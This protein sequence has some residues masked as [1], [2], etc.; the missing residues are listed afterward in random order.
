MHGEGMAS[1]KSTLDSPDTGK[2]RSPA[3][4]TSF[5][6]WFGV[7][8]RWLRH[9]LARGIGSLPDKIDHAA[10]LTEVEDDGNLG[11]R[12]V[13][14]VVMSSAIAT[15]GLLLSSPAVIIGAMLISPLMGPIMLLGF[16]LCVLDFDSMK[17]SLTALAAGVVGALAIAIL[18]VMFSPLRE[19]T[20][21]ILARTRPNLF[22]LLVAIFSGLAG[23]Y[24]VINRKG[25]TIVGVAIATAL[26]PPLAVVGFGVATFNPVVAGGAFLL[27]MTNLLAIALSVTGLAW[28]HGFAT[29]HSKRFARWQT[30]AVLIVFAALSLPLGFAL[31]DIAEET[32]VTNIVRE[33]AM[34]PFDE[35]RSQLSSLSVRFPAGGPIEIEQ[36]VLVHDRVANAEQQLMKRYEDLL[37]RPVNMR[38]SQ[39]LVADDETLDARRIQE[40]AVS[41]IAPLRLQV[42]QIDRRQDTAEAIRAA[43]PFQTQAVDIDDAARAVRIVP[44]LATSLDLAALM[45]AEQQISARFADWSIRILPPVQP[46][47]DVPFESGAELGEAA[48][49]TVDVIVWAMKAWETNSCAIKGRASLGGSASA[50]R[51]LALER[52]EAVAALLKAAGFETTAESGYGES[53]QAAEERR[54]GQVFFQSAAVTPAL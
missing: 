30:A 15:L 43:I 25:A 9:R 52:A 26:M 5:R 31:R 27:F 14:M 19:A 7:R 45:E 35:Q 32:R 2:A 18:I 6:R 49:K 46:L 44:S 10:V 39:V 12:Y 8:V 50:N 48:R 38:L 28:L 22:D 24:S 4:R 3:S 36:T 37:Q 54:L 41:S 17:R 23:G 21:E 40:L 47:P 33:Q 29:I 11:G 51:K 42:E 53:G 20:P 1:D 16:S 34:K 13:F